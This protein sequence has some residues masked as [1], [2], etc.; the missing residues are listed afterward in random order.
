LGWQGEVGW[1]VKAWGSVE[2]F[3]PFCQS[4]FEDSQV[5]A[6]THF[7]AGML[8]APWVV[9]KEFQQPSPEAVQP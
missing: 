9:D 1:T 5:F 2:H 7:A 4:A 3:A 8:V 6:V